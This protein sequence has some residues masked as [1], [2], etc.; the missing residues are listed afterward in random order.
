MEPGPPAGV[1]QATPAAPAW[2]TRTAGAELVRVTSVR[3]VIAGWREN[4]I[5]ADLGQGLRLRWGRGCSSWSAAA[6]RA[7]TDAIHDAFFSGVID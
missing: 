7:G 2:P 4:L 1:P 3:P 6:T 5:R